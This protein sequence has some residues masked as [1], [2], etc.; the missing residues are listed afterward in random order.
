M[1]SPA[2]SGSRSIPEGGGL[3][4]GNPPGGREE[5]EREREMLENTP[6]KYKCGSAVLVELSHFANRS[7][8]S[9]LD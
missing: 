9:T 4:Q 1:R 5:E 3:D 6:A 7:Y 2:A 8:D